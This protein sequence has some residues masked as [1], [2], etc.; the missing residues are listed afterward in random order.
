MHWFE[1]TFE[2]F[3]GYTMIQWQ[4]GVDIW[5]LQATMWRR[6]CCYTIFLGHNNELAVRNRFLERVDVY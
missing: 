1:V 5:P 6:P 4:S 2:V 3:A